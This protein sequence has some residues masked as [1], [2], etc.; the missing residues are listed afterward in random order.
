MK[1][2]VIGAGAIG[3]SLACLLTQ[4]DANVTILEK[5]PKVLSVIQEKGVTL[6]D[7]DK[8]YNGRVTA[9][10]ELSGDIK[11]DCCFS[12]TRAYHL[13][14]AVKSVLPYLKPDACVIS[15]NNG[16]CIDALSE[17]VGDKNSAWCS[18]NFGA[19][20]ESEGC[21]YIKIPGGL[22][23]GS[24]NG[25]TL[26]MRRVIDKLNEVIPVKVTDNI[27]GA[28]YSKMLINSCITSTAVVSG[29]TLGDILSTKAGKRVFVGIIRE[30][31]RVA[32]AS[33]IKVPNYGKGLNYKLF[34]SKNPIGAMYRSIV[35]PHLKKKYGGR[36][37]ATLE[38]LKRGTKTEIDYFNGYVVSLAER[39]GL[40]VPVNKAI[41]ECVKMVESDLSQI[42][43][44][45]IAKIAFAKKI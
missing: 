2:L 22:T 18:I 9:L 3:G 15:M 28:L 23:I 20:I 34:A 21:Y 1:I 35:F 42:K 44:E 11:Y 36:T 40:D 17:V 6:R 26:S 43:S 5:N 33:G 13:E 38:A 27:V 45:N 7:G 24:K 25:L 29:D 32:K 37:S 19:G 31:M 16:V 4:T 39:Y 10:A 14:S 12:A 8:S 41:V 30:G